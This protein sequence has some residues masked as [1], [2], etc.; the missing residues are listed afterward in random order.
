MKERDKEKVLYVLSLQESGL[1]YDKILE[2]ILKEKIFTGKSA[3]SS[4]VRM[5]KRNNYIKRGDKFIKISEGA[6]SATDVILTT[7]RKQK[8]VKEQY[9][10]VAPFMQNKKQLENLQYLAENTEQIKAILEGKISSN[11]NNHFTE[12]LDIPEECQCES[13]SEVMR[14]TIR[15]KESIWKDFTDFSKKLPQYKKTDLLNHALYRYMND[16]E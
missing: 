4:L 15:I 14:T 9:Y 7:N 3:S 12:I 11:T 6:E 16:F 10:E 8:P 13:E 2:I 5:M 1:S